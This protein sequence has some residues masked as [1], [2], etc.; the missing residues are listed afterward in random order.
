MNEPKTSEPGRPGSIS[1]QVG[2]GNALLVTN[3]NSFNGTSSSYKDTDLTSDF[4][5]CFRDKPGNFWSNN[6]LGRDSSSINIFYLFDLT[7]L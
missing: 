7:R 1:G 4:S 5:R 2:D 6:S 3:D